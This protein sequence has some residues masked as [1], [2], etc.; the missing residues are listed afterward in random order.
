VGLE[1]SS[2][3]LGNVD[4]FQE[5]SPLFSCPGFISAR[6]VVLFGFP[7]II[8]RQTVAETVGPQSREY[9]LATQEEQVRIPASKLKRQCV[10]NE[11][12]AQTALVSGPDMGC[13]QTT[14]RK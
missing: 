8:R 14:R 6:A 4:M 3:P 7:D 9:R 12:S 2:H 11:R 13:Q 5:V 1:Y 10:H